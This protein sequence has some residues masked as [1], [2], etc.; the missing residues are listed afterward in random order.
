MY[1]IIFEK[2]LASISSNVISDPFSFNCYSWN[3]LGFSTMFLLSLMSFSIFS[4]SDFKSYI[5]PILKLNHS[6]LSYLIYCNLLDS[7]TFS[8]QFGDFYLIFKIS[9][10]SFLKLSS[11]TS[12]F[13]NILIIINLKFLFG[14]SSDWIISFL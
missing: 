6:L 12:S 11:L 3:I 10:S 2:L 1:L 5:L 9:P 7:I 4:L 13:L 8:F 14:N